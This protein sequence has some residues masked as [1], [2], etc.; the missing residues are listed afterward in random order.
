[1]RINKFYL[2]LAFGLVSI[3]VVLWVTFGT[4]QNK[5]QTGGLK[6]KTLANKASYVLGEPVNLRFELLNEGE[7]EVKIITGG[8][9][10]GSIKIFVSAED[11]KYN[12][13]VSSGWERLQGTKIPLKN[14]E[15]YRYDS[16]NLLW[17]EMKHAGSGR[18]SVYNGY[19]F[20]APG[21]Y[22]IKAGYWVVLNSP[23]TE[24]TP[25]EITVIEPMGEDSLVWEEIKGNREIAYLMQKGTFDEFREKEKADLVATVENIVNKFPNS[26]Y[27]KYLR[28]NLE[29][30]KRDEVK[31]KSFYKNID[32]K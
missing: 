31:R 1:M 4:T 15:S 25:I 16:V 18:S 22:T 29:N 12:P 5:A 26:V 19:A 28:E 21:K 20:P 32:P 9:E 6:L 3:F 30:F 7:E 27:S 8:V 24:S 11:D 10:V 13:Y 2:G 23:E 14:G 17:N